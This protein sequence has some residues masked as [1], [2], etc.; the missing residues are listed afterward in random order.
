MK[1]VLVVAIHPDDETLGCGGTLLKHKESGDEIHWLIATEMTVEHGFKES[2]VRKRKE[3]I[4]KVNRLYNFD[5][6]N[7]LGFP[8]TKIDNNDTSFLVNKIS[9]KY[10][11]LFDRITSNEFEKRDYI[12]INDAIELNIKNELKK[13]V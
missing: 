11:E 2:V 4:Q 3:E 12:G 10:I 8:T 9:K 6:I 1:K 13:H 5:S 7:R